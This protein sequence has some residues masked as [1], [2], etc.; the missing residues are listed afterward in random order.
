MG[1][2][3]PDKSDIKTVAIIPAAGAGIRMGA[4]RA[5]QFLDIQG[6]PVLAFTLLR[7]EES[8]VIDSVFLVVPAEDI[9]YCRR[10]I[11]ERFN[12]R[13]V[14]KII[15]GGKRRQDSVRN[16]VEATRGEFQRI[17]VHDGVRPFI[18]PG[19]IETVVNAADKNRAV[20]M[21]LPARETVKETDTD[22]MVVKTHDRKTV[23]L[24]QTPQV[25]RYDDILAAH[26]KA[27]SE[28]W[29]EIT[30][31]SLLMEKMGIPVKVIPGTEGNIKITTPSDLE[32]A[33]FVLSR[34]K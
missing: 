31:D 14:E 27:V 28:C 13:K 19:I 29:D 26:K 5:K 23:W 10:E 1:K 2:Q 32:F 25:F 21:G 3:M 24:I 7:F 34:K 6:R 16:G 20:I 9:D 11:V 15:A 30:D 18:D 22:G 12:L 8:P 17:L 4:D 33:R